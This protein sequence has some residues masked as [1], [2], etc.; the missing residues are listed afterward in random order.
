LI[1]T[2]WLY[3]KSIVG[4]TKH[5]RVCGIPPTWVNMAHS[6]EL[7]LQKKLCHFW[8]SR[9]LIGQITSQFKNHIFI[10]HPLSVWVYLMLTFKFCC[11]SIYNV[12]S[13]GCFQI[14]KFVRNTNQ[15]HRRQ[16]TMLQ[17]CQKKVGSQGSLKCSHKINF[18]RCNFWI[19]WKGPLKCK[20]L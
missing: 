8:P 16:L 9:Q 19:R 5:Y 7:A 11:F 13:H 20:P 10:I 15:T 18:K 14:C 4:G 3:L 1:N 17:F 2:L 12:C 6:K